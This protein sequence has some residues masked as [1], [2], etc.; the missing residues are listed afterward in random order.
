MDFKTIRLVGICILI[1]HFSAASAQAYNSEEKDEY[2]AEL[3]ICGGASYYIGD[4]TSIYFNLLN[5]R[6]LSGGF[7]RY[8]ID[9]RVAV[10]GELV[11]SGIAGDGISDNGVLSGD[12]VGEYNFFELEKN[13]YK[14]FSKIFSPYIFAGAG[15]MS[16]YY[17]SKNLINPNL[18]MGI[19]MKLKLGNRWN[20][21]LQ[22]SNRLLLADNLEGIAQYNNKNGLNGLNIFNN[23]LLSSLTLGV[24]F[25]IWKKEC[26]C[27]NLNNPK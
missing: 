19:G 7:L 27:M 11:L 9:N 1:F 3:G 12:I 10:R 24:S 25:D 4:A 5:I 6:E 18:T 8:R 2:K 26:N 13:P 16:Y 14:R 17:D 20:L 23:D 15:L 21:N 22:W